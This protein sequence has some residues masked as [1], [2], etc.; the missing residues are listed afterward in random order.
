MTLAGCCLFLCEFSWRG[1]HAGRV[2]GPTGQCAAHCY[3]C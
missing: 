1:L 2:G 3:R